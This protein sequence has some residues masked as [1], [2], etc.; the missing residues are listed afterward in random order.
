M[1]E[2]AP[3]KPEPWL[4]G[5]HPPTRGLVEAVRRATVHAPRRLRVEQLGALLGGRRRVHLVPV[6]QPLVHRTVGQRLPL[7]CDEAARLLRGGRGVCGEVGDGVGVVRRRAEQ[8]MGAQHAAAAGQGTRRRRRQAQG[9]TASLSLPQ[10]PSARIHLACTAS[11]CTTV[12]R[13]A[14]HTALRPATGRPSDASRSSLAKSRCGG[15]GQGGG[16]AVVWG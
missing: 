10:P 2:A 13:P 1:G 6:T 11:S 7:V 5:Y 9:H 3:E 14:S 15:G 16:A 8:R 12:G 4:P